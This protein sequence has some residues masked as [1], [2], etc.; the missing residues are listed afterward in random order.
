MKEKVQK[1]TIIMG[2]IN[3]LKKTSRQNI[4]KHIEDLNSIINIK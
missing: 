1:Y 2:D 4:N 3:T